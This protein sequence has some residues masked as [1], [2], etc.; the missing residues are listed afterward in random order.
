[1]PDTPILLAINSYKARSGIL[2]S[3]RVVNMYAEAAP[4]QAPFQ[5][6]LYGTP[7][8]KI[9]KDIKV[10]NPIY[11][12]E[13]M[14]NDIF[15]VSG[16]SVYKINAAK[17][18]TNIGTMEV[19]PNR[20]M[21]TNNG[22]Q[23]TILTS[24]GRAFYCTTTADSLLEIT[25]GDY[26]LSSSVT[27]MDGY[28]IFTKIES[29]RFQISGI[30]ATQNY[31]ALKVDFVLANSTNLV[32]TISN[33]LEVWFFKKDITLVYYNSGNGTF[34]FERKNGIMIEKGLAAK[35]AVSTLDNNFYFLG[36]DRMI[37]RTSGYQII[38][39]STP[40]ISKA[41][42]SYGRVDDA[43]SFTYTQ[44]GHKFYVIT[45]PTASKTWVHDIMTG[46][47]HER[48]SLDENSQPKKWRANAHVLF[49]DKNLVGDNAMG[50]LYELDLDTYDE[51]GTK[52]V[53]KVISTTQ[54]DNYKRDGVADL[55]L[56]MDTGVGI[57]SGKGVD[58]KIAMRT[59]I[60]GGQTYS[61]E[62]T[63]PL[64]KQGKYDTEVVWNRVAYG[65]SLILELKISDP[66]KRA[67]VQALLGITRGQK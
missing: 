47:W 64:G 8:L 24:S 49:D 62:L 11:G 55:T 13:K 43:F 40:P 10:F 12:I 48:E 60:D 22:T 16:I 67:I 65:R 44:D 14:G 57:N 15:V 3:E 1:M 52:M 21:M 19:T 61:K 41:I 50:K 27:T 37:Y 5:A 51:D 39:I 17:T 23:V 38:P 30:N 58:P 29:N 28:T 33:N 56:V 4:K 20:V 46:L 45:F 2:S 32:R 26:A 42:E 53:S 18:V 9:W 34:P 59:S 25:D 6:V 7:G 31:N 35:F 54:F 63:Q 66:V 36:D